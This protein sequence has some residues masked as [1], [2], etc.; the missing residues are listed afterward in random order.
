MPEQPESQSQQFQTDW[1]KAVA[2]ATSQGIS[3]ASYLPVYQLDL[4]RVQNGE[5]PMGVA[6]RNLEILAAHDPNQVTSAPQDNPSSSPT[7]SNIF[8]NA[9]SDAGKIATGLAGIFTGSF[10][11]QLWDSAKSTVDDVIH[12][13]RLAAPTIGGTIGNW[14]DETLLAYLP[15]ATDI[16]Q[17]LQAD[18]SLT[19]DAGAKKL[20]QH[21]LVSLLDLLG[22]GEGGIVGKLGEH[23][24]GGDAAAAYAASA[25]KEGGILKAIGQIKLPK[26]GV[27]LSP[28]Q[29]ALVEQLSV[30]DVITKMAAKLGPGG[31]GVGPALSDLGSA[32]NAASQMGATQFDWLMEGPARAVSD[33]SQEQVQLLGK[34][35]STN[36]Q[37][38][39]ESVRKAMDDPALDP[40]VKDALVQMIDGPLKFAKEG[41]LLSGDLRPVQP[42][43][44][45]KEGLYLP[46]ERAHSGVF[47]AMR[48]RDV[49]RL[50]ALK[51]LGRLQPHVEATTALEAELVKGT[52]QF[53]DQLSAARKAVAADADPTLR[54]NATQDVANP[55]KFRAK[56]GISKSTQV[57]A[58]VDEGGLADQML[59]RIKENHDPVQIRA[60]AKAMK[61][62]LSK[63]GP[64]SVN[65]AESPAL[66][67]LATTVDGLIKWADLYQK[68]GEE[69]DRAI[70][71]EVETQRGL[72]NEH[73]AFR[74][75]QLKTLKDR[76]TV[77]RTNLDETFERS[78]A[79]T[80]GAFTKRL[81]EQMEYKT[82]AT[83][84]TE[85]QTEAA[86][87]RASRPVLTQLMAKERAEKA[88]INDNVRKSIASAREDLT[89]RTKLARAE[90]QRDL[91]KLDK[92]QKEELENFRKVTKNEKA[93]MGDVM[94][95][96]TAYAKAVNKFS[97][98]VADHPSDEYR[99]V[100]VMLMQKHMLASE[101]SATLIA[102][103]MKHADEIGM[104]AGQIAKLRSD[105][106][107]LG[108]YM[109]TRFNEIFMQ[110]NISP[111]VAEMAA[112][113]MR[114]ASESGREELKQLIARGLTVQYIPASTDIDAK[115]SRD[116]VAPLIGKG[117]PK[118]DMAKARVWDMTPQLNDFAVGI[119]KAVIQQIQRDATIELT[120]HY[121][122]PMTLTKTQ[123]AN[124][125]DKTMNPLDKELGGNLA[126]QSRHMTAESLGLSAFHPESLF[127]FRLPRWG[128]DEVYLPTPIVKALEQLMDEKGQNIKLLSSSTK[129][130]RYSILGLSPRYDAHI[131]FGGTMMAA[132]RVS[133]WA[134][135]FI[136]KGAKALRD[137]ALPEDLAG[138]HAVEE[139][140]Q[141]AALSLY[142]RQAAKDVHGM[143]VDEHIEKRQGI[144]RA[145]A[146]PVHLLRAAADINFRFTRYVRDL[147][148]AVVYLDGA[149]KA[150]RRS[151]KIAVEDPVTG[152]M[153]KISPDR[154]MAEGMK[155]VESVFGNLGRMSPFERQV[156]QTMMPFYGWEKHILSYVMTFPFDHPWRST[157]LSQMAYNSSND[158]PLADPIRIQLLY[159]LGSPDSQGNV[160]AV[161][162][163]SLDPF[164]D[165]ANYASW[166]GF[167]ESLNPA[168]AA[169]LTMAF[170]SG[171]TYGSS[172]LYPTVSYNSF[173]GIETANSQGNVWSGLQQWIPQ[174]GAAQSA[175]QAVTGVRSLWS[176]D[177]SAAIKS[178]L[179]N[180][181][182]PFVTPPVNLKQIAAEDEGARYKVA[183]TT[184]YN[185]FQSGDFSTLAGYKTVPNPL[186]PA[187]EITPAA[188]EQLYKQAQAATPGVAPI[189]SLLPPPSPYG[190]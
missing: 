167:F 34:I 88:R 40:K 190:W 189:E 9:V 14:L 58:V 180:L 52:K 132:L 165:V 80:R 27:S 122:R 63:W 171:A 22:V 134:L 119:K 96:I 68:E 182:I 184:A 97:E 123:V 105:P 151:S 73:S 75:L 150:E 17:V 3:A 16:G 93:G 159:F 45:G 61:A 48:D 142:N 64:K 82:W 121:L 72:F 100:Q 31:A 117:V 56:R 53:Q 46:T 76:H 124:F 179:E 130:F 43:Y 187:Y 35:L 153:V 154:A 176:T 113:A 114:E 131:L 47:D 90:H 51:E 39:G 172:S 26:S 152:K 95:Q 23:G 183:S 79:K 44:G 74:D 140:G 1:S 138:R 50:G 42:L 65:A 5:Y 139:G 173:Y 126:L 155:A 62:R 86:G 71:G 135:T 89:A 83:A 98:A 136:G 94:R 166:T 28:G 87:E 30:K 157:V 102:Q 24:L 18:P 29:V 177:R 160:N 174:V 148:A 6:Q 37:T 32:Y 156:A 106:Q 112:N 2:W 145:L 185:A 101:H 91:L 158:V 21:P 104:S 15:G 57:H 85:S 19:G 137:G 133:P 146:K 49:A 33:L 120:E 169:P 107:L 78:M 55:T 11:K 186:N 125:I 143:M 10:E 161:D 147:Q 41:Q 108:E 20:L 188:L 110:P 144:T 168:L 4:N 54:G 69:V 141:K 178:I 13:S 84:I 149:A 163:R 7:P 162:I 116:S 67:S 170:G 115:L 129:L 81:S 181:N 38:L 103:T 77:E 175:L 164:R 36:D 127:G 109:V 8:G 118:P 66:A 99:D 59:D 92:R 25:K 60:V 128:N 12:P 70:N 111:E